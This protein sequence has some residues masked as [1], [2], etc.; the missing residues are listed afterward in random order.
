[1]TGL[2]VFALFLIVAV[3]ASLILADS[4]LRGVRI[5]RSLRAEALMM[6]HPAAVGH[7]DIQKCAEMVS[8]SLL[9]PINRAASS[10]RP[11]GLVVL[12]GLAEPH[13]CAAA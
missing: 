12:A 6:Q 4:G 11:A 7:I 13:L 8:P 9:R 3:T 5:F 2:F 1:M 10:R